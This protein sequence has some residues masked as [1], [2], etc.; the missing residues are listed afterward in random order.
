LSLWWKLDMQC[1]KLCDFFFNR[2]N[3]INVVCFML[4]LFTLK[5]INKCL[6]RRF[7]QSKKKLIKFVLLRDIFQK[8]RDIWKIISSLGGQGAI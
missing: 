1:K 6:S 7:V 2:E 4:Y 3:Y 5:Y 8:I